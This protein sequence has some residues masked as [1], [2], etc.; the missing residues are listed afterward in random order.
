MRQLTQ[1]A[2]RRR[3]NMRTSGLTLSCA[4]LQ[5]RAAEGQ[6]A[7]KDIPA[8]TKCIEKLGEQLHQEEQV[9]PAACTLFTGCKGS[10]VGGP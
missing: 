8:L 6:Q 10:V 5:E 1:H 7:E 4:G 9:R 2:W 3:S